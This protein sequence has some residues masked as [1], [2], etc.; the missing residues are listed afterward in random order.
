MGEKEE[1]EFLSVFDAKRIFRNLQEEATG[2]EVIKLH[3]IWFTRC[4]SILQKC[5]SLDN[6]Q[7]KP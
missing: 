7:Q 1:K 3:F 2:P 5:Y 4:G 6:D